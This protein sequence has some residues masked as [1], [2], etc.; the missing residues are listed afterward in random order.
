[1]TASQNSAPHYD[2]AIAGAGIIGLSTA[3]FLREQGL[4]VIVFDKGDVAYEQSSRNWGWMRTISQ[5]MA[6]LSLALD[7]RPLWRQW[8]EEGG[9]GFRQ[10]GLLS[11]ADNP[12]EWSHLQ[13]W[14]S[15]AAGQGLDARFATN[16]EV[17][18][19]LPQFH[20]R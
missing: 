7:S 17:T 3:L 2:V 8:A 6:E 19:I 9:F 15:Q 11:V 14:L 18:R 20:R 1:M 13:T 16:D 10:C 12:D 4:S 5:D